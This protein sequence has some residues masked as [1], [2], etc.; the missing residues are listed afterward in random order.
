MTVVPAKRKKGS[1]S[2]TPL[3]VEPYDHV[4]L[5]LRGG[6]QLRIRMEPNG[7]YQILVAGAVDGKTYDARGFD[8]LEMLKT[9]EIEWNGN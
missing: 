4:S 5:V 9:F 1:T 6:H 2:K 3:D 7:W 8:L